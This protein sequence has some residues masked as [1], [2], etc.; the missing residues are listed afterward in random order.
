MDD[1]IFEELNTPAP[2]ADPAVDADAADSATAPAPTD[3]P[4]DADFCADSA[5]APAPA[6]ASCTA[7]AAPP[8]AAAPSAAGKALLVTAQP[9]LFPTTQKKVRR[10]GGKLPAALIV[11]LVPLALFLYHAA[12][13]YAETYS[14]TYVYR[15][16]AEFMTIALF[17]SLAWIGLFLVA[18]LFRRRTSVPLSEQ[19]SVIELHREGVVQ[20]SN[21]RRVVIPFDA[22][23]A[24]FEDTELLAI[25][26]E[27]GRR[28]CWQSTDLTSYDA[29]I[30]R[31]TILENIPENTVFFKNPFCPLLTVPTPLPH[32]VT[33]PEPPVTARGNR[34]PNGTFWQRLLHFFFRWG[35]VLLYVCAT[36]GCL[37]HD[38][39]HL[40]PLHLS[41]RTL[42]TAIFALIV[43]PAVVGTWLW[44]DTR[45]CEC[46]TPPVRLWTTPYGIL[47]SDGMNQWV[48]P[49][50]TYRKTVGHHGVTLRSGEETIR[51]PY[52]DAGHLD[53][54]PNLNNDLYNQ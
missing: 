6:P 15:R 23:T 43:C 42:W 9:H 36:L 45:R 21:Y 51:I 3:T 24:F 11:M 4:T 26:T 37:I 20:R 34:Y 49:H 54:P 16:S 44:L 27:D 14:P 50:G 13:S 38:H 47:L 18:Q 53:L 46:T 7:D 22:V 10:L 2:S 12:L 28:I 41:M 5:T 30:L 1:P 17:A 8:T 35:G 40:I 19:P 33:T 39:L 32:V 48:Y 31:R 25:Q 52:S 29:A